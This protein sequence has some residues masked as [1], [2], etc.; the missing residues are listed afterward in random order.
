[1]PVTN[2]VFANFTGWL[3]EGRETVASVSCSERRPCYNIDYVNY[4]LRTG[5]NGTSGGR[6]ASC[7]WVEEGVHGVDC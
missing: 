5:V 2:V 7:K 1:M 6:R 3:E 4:D